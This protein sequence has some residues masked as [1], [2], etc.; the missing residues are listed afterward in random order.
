MSKIAV[1]YLGDEELIVGYSTLPAD[2]YVGIREPYVNDFWI[3]R[4]DGSIDHER[5][6]RLTIPEHERILDR[7]AMALADA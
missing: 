4:F 3:E 5:T 6:N 1:C 2:P 7:L